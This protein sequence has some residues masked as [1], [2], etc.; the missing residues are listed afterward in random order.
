MDVRGRLRAWL[1]R[2]FRLIIQAVVRVEATGLERIAPTGPLIV[3][4]NH[5]NWLDAVLTY[6]LAPR[7]LV[8][9]SKIE[10]FQNP[11]MAPVVRFGGAIPVRRGTPD[12]TAIRRAL[13]ALEAG[14][15]LL[16]DP[17]GTR[18]H[19][20]RLQPAR[21]GVIFLALR[22]GVPILPIAVWGQE[23]FWRNL[24]RLT[25]TLVHLRV[26]YPFYLRAHEG[27]VRRE[28]RERILRE[29]M[30]QLAAL[31]PPAYRG[32]YADLENA[33]EEHLVFPP[34]SQSNLLA[35]DGRGTG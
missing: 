14:E 16:I 33:T 17:E 32:A 31:L 1:H 10:N 6:L 12:V 29:V 19:H 13:D 26:G 34:G 35:A 28:E 7:H 22:T 30:Y 15:A 2:I 3:I 27:R 18:S 5:V 21:S 4:N 23:R 25:R 8:G 20:G 11:L 9:F 24:F